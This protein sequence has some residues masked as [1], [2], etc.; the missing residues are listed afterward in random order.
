MKRVL[1]LVVAA[2]VVYYVLHSPQIAG[3]SVHAAGAN[4]WHGARLAASALTKFLDTTF[5]R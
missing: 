1:L 4:V 2:F 3:K 5:S